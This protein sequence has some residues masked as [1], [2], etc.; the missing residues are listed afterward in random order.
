MALRNA[1]LDAVTAAVGDGGLLRI[2]DGTRPRTGGA[3]TTLLAE[4]TC[5]APFAPPARHGVLMAN[6][7]TPDPSAKASGTP[8]WARLTTRAGVFVA[9]MD[10][11]VE[12]VLDTGSIVAGDVVACRACIITAGNR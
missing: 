10:A 1:R 12:L 6:P 2:Y 11:G 4:L 7:V 5:G 8:T 9:D 3:A